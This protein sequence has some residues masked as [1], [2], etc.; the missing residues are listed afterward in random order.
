MKSFAMKAISVWGGLLFAMAG[1]AAAQSKMHLGHISESWGDTPGKVSLITI[2]EEEAQIAATHA[3]LA[4]ASKEDL[5]TMRMHITHVENAVDPSVV[6]SGPGKGYGV[7]K[8]AQGVAAHMGF[9]AAAADAGDS[10]KMHSVHIIQ[11]AKN[12]ERW[13]NEIMTKSGYIKGGASDVASQ[14]YTDEVADMTGWI[15]N[16]H[17]ANGDGKISWEEGEGGLAQMKAHLGYIQ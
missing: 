2:L 5:K 13:G 16:G 8:A 11:C 14:F 1:G 3:K 10:L 9:A 15:L 6:K 4:V 7:I 12:I 17:D